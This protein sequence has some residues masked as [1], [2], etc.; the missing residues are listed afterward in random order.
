MS[1]RA[2][3][4]CHGC[5]AGI[6]A[7]AIRSKRSMPVSDSTHVTSL[8]RAIGAL[9][10]LLAVTGCPPDPKIGCFA[11]VNPG[12]YQI[13]LAQLHSTDP[14]CGALDSLGV[15]SVVTMTVIA[16]KRQFDCWANEAEVTLPG[17]EATGPAPYAI[18]G[19][20]QTSLGVAVKTVA[21]G[22]C[23]G[24]H[25]IALKETI[26]SDGGARFFLQRDFLTSN[27]EDCPTFMAATGTALCADV[28]TATVT[29][30]PH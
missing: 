12:T 27:A 28:W 17:V 1:S 19:N 3:R 15:G 4:G 9:A 22:S 10:M 5:D 13:T 23:T 8:A 16:T 21:I 24:T 26:A 20:H 18:G 6:D 7:G 14:G 11:S 30:S 2:H 29:P 25:E